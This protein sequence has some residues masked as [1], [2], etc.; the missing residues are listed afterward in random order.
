[1]PRISY[2]HGLAIYMY[3]NEGAHAVPHFHV[4]GAAARASVGFDGTPIAG[5]LDP[6]ELRLVQRWAS[7]RREELQ[8][9]WELAR[10]S[11]PLLQIAPLE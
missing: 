10:R 6:A 2:F 4:V 9:N 1:M 3:W 7:L 8:S 11:E 5:A